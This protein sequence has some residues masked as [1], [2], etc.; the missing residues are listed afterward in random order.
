MIDEIFEIGGLNISM[1]KQKIAII[2]NESR[3]Q[4]LTVINDKDFFCIEKNTASSI[5][6]L[7]TL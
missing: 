6:T 4:I 5:Y 2:E 3:Q 1:K 7:I